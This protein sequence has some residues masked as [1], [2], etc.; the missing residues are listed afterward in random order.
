MNSLMIKYRLWKMRRRVRPS[1]EFRRALWAELEIKLPR[2]SFLQA[3]AWQRLAVPIGVLVLSLG[4]T[5]V[6]AYTS[7]SVSWGN[8][9]FQI[10]GRGEN[11]EDRLANTPE[12]SARLRLKKMQRRM[13]EA[14]KIAQTKPDVAEELIDAAR[15]EFTRGLDQAAKISD[16]KLRKEVLSKF[17]KG[18][19]E[20]LTRI[21]NIVEKN[22]ARFRDITERLLEAEQRRLADK[23]IQVKDEEIRTLLERRI[24]QR[25]MMLDF[26]YLDDLTLPEKDLE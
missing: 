1:R 18:D 17:I 20:Q 3:L 7:P 23:L 8:P 5:S 4:A 15:G 22:P 13:S 2:R 9:L 16:I 6:Y 14:E 19:P 10:K 12:A 26:L 25:E 24:K 21:Q 11:I